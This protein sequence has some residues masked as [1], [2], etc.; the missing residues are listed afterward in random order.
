DFTERE[1]VRIFDN[2]NFGYRRITVER[3]LRLNFC[4]NDERLERVKNAAAFLA[5]ATSRK[6]KDTKAAEQEIAE[7]KEQQAAILAAL[8]PLTREGVIRNRETFTKVLHAALDERNVRV[9]AALFKVIVTALSERDETADICADKN[10]NLEP[11]PE[12]RD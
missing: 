9:P 3:P 4:I 5:L 11:D 6:R 12:L 7:G 1:Q 8:I 10:G 2:E